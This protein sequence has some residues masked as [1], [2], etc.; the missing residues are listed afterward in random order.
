MFRKKAA[1]RVSWFPLCAFRPFSSSAAPLNPSAILSAD[2][3]PALANSISS[4][5]EWYEPHILLLRGYA[6]WQRCIRESL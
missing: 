1:G 4:K 2:A 6:A 3:V 5:Q